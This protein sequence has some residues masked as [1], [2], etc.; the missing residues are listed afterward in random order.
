MADEH[1]NVN[2]RTCKMLCP[3]HWSTK[4]LKKNFD[5]FVKE[6]F[7]QLELDLYNALASFMQEPE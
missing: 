3:C 7:P 2:W 4:V 6:E 5:L 1:Y